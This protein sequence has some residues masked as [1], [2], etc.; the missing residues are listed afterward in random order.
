M[1]FESSGGRERDD[2]VRAVGQSVGSGRSTAVEVS[3]IEAGEVVS[4]RRQPGRCDPRQTARPPTDWRL[5]TV[6]VLYLPMNE[7]G[8][9]P[10][11]NG[12]ITRKSLIWRRGWDSNPRGA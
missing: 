7:K 1:A 12:A 5:G 4:D 2:R 11:V 3:R 10:S 6:P 8:I 9:P